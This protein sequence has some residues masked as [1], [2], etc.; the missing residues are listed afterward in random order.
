MLTQAE[1]EQELEARLAKVDDT[2]TELRT[3]LIREAQAKAKYDVAE[4]QAF[5][6]VKETV[7][8]TVEEAKR[9]AKVKVREDHESYLMAEATA[10]GSKLALGA[11]RDQLS[12]YQSLLR[13]ISSVAVGGR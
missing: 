6:A 3:A 11:L 5:L 9:L 13:A 10:T 4:A 12:G 2:L 1:L 8:C 7:K